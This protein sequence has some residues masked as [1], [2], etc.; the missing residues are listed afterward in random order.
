MILLLGVVF[1]PDEDTLIESGD[2][3]VLFLSNKRS[4]KDVERLFQVGVTFV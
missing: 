3:V 2:H 4:I 1:K